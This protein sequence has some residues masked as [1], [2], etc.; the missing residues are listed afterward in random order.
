MR[1]KASL[2]SAMIPHVVHMP[3]VAY[4]KDF[5]AYRSL[6]ETIIFFKDINWI[7]PD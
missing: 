4:M 6:S 2:H 3:Q 1:H 5:W 7:S